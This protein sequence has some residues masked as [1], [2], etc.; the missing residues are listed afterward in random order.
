MAAAL[1]LSAWL[2]GC[3]GPTKW[4]G[5]DGPLDSAAPRDAQSLDPT[6]LPPHAAVSGVYLYWPF[7]DASITSAA[8][9]SGHDRNGILTNAPAP[10]DPAPGAR[11]NNLRGAFFNGPGA[12]ATLDLDTALGAFTVALWIKPADVTPARVFTRQIESG[13]AALS[14]GVGPAATF[15]LSGSDESAPCATRSDCVASAAPIVQ[16]AWVHL[17]ASLALDGRLQLFVDGHE[18]G[19]AQ[20]EAVRNEG[21]RVGLGAANSALPPGIR[22]GVD[23]LILYEGALKEV[24]IAPLAARQ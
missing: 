14:L 3:D 18:A 1:A 21:G 5:A 10:S 22:A 8:D 2:V 9:A 16:D 24:D 7:D 20:G 15:E 11:A 23:E 13:S 4:I 12:T 6:L 17:A 19:S